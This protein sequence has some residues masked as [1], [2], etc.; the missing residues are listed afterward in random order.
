MVY[1]HCIILL[2]YI[3]YILLIYINNRYILWP[4][5]LKNALNIFP[6][7]YRGVEQLEDSEIRSCGS[8]CVSVWWFLCLVLSVPS[9]SV[10]PSQLRIFCEL[11][12]WDTFPKSSLLVSHPGMFAT[13][14]GI[15]NQ[16][17]KISLNGSE[18][19]WA[20][21]SLPGNFT[22]VGPG[23]DQWRSCPAFLKTC[24]ESKSF[25]FLIN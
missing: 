10:A 6:T 15:Q 24:R 17:W 13:S 23:R 16:Q 25:P 8:S 21:P 12:I 3:Y 22:L 18:G 19:F 7:N 1:Q 20:G 4:A 9:E 14:R 11:G 5:L 2:I